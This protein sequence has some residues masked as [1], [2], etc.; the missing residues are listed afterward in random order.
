MKQT[1]E[2]SEEQVEAYARAFGACDTVRAGG[3]WVKINKRGR[4]VESEL[5]STDNGYRLNYTLRRGRHK[6]RIGIVKGFYSTEPKPYTIVTPKDFVKD[7]EVK[8]GDKFVWLG[9]TRKRHDGM[10]TFGRYYKVIQ[11][12]GK[13]TVRDDFNRSLNITLIMTLE[14][15]GIIPLYENVKRE[16]VIEFEVGD[17]VKV[18]DK[19]RVGEVVFRDECPEVWKVN[20][21]Y[22]VKFNDD[23]FDTKWYTEEELEL[24][25]LTDILEKLEKKA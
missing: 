5:K 13:L 1:F 20:G 18:K 15:W 12:N 10:F 24:I 14:E 9:Y 11:D 17:Y 25:E 7:Y 22:V 19:G 3:E 2:W 8:E 4:I 16:E 23:E 6:Q 21:L